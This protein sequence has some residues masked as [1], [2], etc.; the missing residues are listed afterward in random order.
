MY[1]II[2]K[3]FF[4]KVRKVLYL[5]CIINHAPLF[6]KQAT[7][8]LHHVLTSRGVVYK[9]KGHVTLLIP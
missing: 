1:L 6:T 7:T 9:Q 8:W 4:F 2:E 3:F 5:I